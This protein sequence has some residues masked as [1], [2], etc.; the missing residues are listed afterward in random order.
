MYK[1][2]RSKAFTLRMKICHRGE[3]ECSPPTN[4]P[5]LGPS[6]AW[7]PSLGVGCCQDT[8]T[9]QYLRIAGQMFTEIANVTC[10][11]LGTSHLLRENPVPLAITPP[12]SQ[13]GPV[14]TN[15][16]SALCL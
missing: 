10:F 2:L 14:P 8:L 3:S 7:G 1:F 12:S 6:E 13:P 11:S 5:E 9:P 4:A 16:E 15:H